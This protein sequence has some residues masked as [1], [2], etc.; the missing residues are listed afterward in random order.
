MHVSR[1]LVLLFLLAGCDS[2]EHAAHPPDAEASEHDHV[3]RAPHGG[4]LV[5]LAEEGLHLEILRES[6]QTLR[7]WVLGAHAEQPVRIQQPTLELQLRWNGG[8][9]TLTLDAIES[10]MTGE[11][12]GDTSEFAA[13]L[14]GLPTGETLA[15][16]LTRL[17]ARGATFEKVH[18][19]L[20]STP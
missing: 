6:E 5:V 11:T 10:K 15:G 7:A 3:H 19:E 1:S 9:Q 2:H 13:V 14:E 12:L 8:E 20:P 4:V 16:V 17:T 18:F